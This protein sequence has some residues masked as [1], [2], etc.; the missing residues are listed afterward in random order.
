[1]SA[2]EIEIARG[3]WADANR[4]L[5]EARNDRRRYE[6][7]HRQVDALLAELRRRLGGNFTLTEL[8]QEYG[9]AERWSRDA[10]TAVSESAAELQDLALVED[11]AFHLYAR[12]A[13]DY[14]P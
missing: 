13:V 6:R 14:E 10:A 7:L 11:A 1:M 3:Q 2:T 5:E 9:R 4:R 8:V 12:G